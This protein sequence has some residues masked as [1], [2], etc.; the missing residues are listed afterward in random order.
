VEPCKKILGCDF[1]LA[2]SLERGGR[3]DGNV[4]EAAKLLLDEI[5]G[6][7]R[8]RG[9]GGSYLE[10]GRR[11]LEGNGGSA[12]IDSDHL[13]INLPEHARAEDHAAVLHAG[14]RIARDAQTAAQ[15]KLGRGRISVLAAVSDGHQSWGHHLNVMVGRQLFDDL[16]TRKPHLLGFF[17]THLATAAVFAGHGHVGPSNKR[18]AC[19]YQLSQRADWFEELVGHQTTHQ[20][21]LLNLRDEA[22][23]GRGLARMHIIAFDNVL[24][25]VANLLKAG[26]TQL[27][28]AMAEAGWADPAAQLDDPLAAFAEVSRDLTLRKPL[29]L[30]GR[31][32]HNTAVEVQRRLAD[33]AGEFVASGE[34]GDSVPGADAIVA[35]WRE[36]LD[37]LARRDLDALAGRCDWVLKYLLLDR[38]RGRRGLSWASPDMKCLDLLFSSLDPQE[39]LFWQMAAA[40]QVENMPAAETVERFV[41]EPPDDTRAYLRAHALRRFGEHVASLNWDRIRFRLPTDRY[42]WS[43]TV[44]AM[45]DPSRLGRAESEP[46]LA[47]CATLAELVEAVGGEPEPEPYYSHAGRGDSWSYGPPSWSGWGRSSSW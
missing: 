39:G 36:T 40:G 28:L 27:V 18:P 26:T 29:P 3:G 2:N 32:R 6:Y 1:E 10:W 33:L 38:F 43:E 19:D 17:G 16:F 13:E 47:K 45:P 14:L 25:P 44:L 30:A 22:H 20:R 4:S 8:E 7:P 5:R 46:V 42:W 24:C 9:W 23:A 37:R 31:G 11:F 12:Y 15:A 41:A 34:C 35:L 21:P